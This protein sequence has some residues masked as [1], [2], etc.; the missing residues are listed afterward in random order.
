MKSIFK[1][2]L[3]LLKL[4]NTYHTK[5]SQKLSNYIIILRDIINYLDKL[6]SE[7]GYLRVRRLNVQ[8]FI[9][10]SKKENSDLLTLNLQIL[11]YT[12]PN[13]N[14]VK[15]LDLTFNS[16]LFW[17]CNSDS[18]KRLCQSKLN[19]LVKLSCAF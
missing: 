14:T 5:I 1:L 17:K 15:Y 2:V 11:K 16:T 6:A 7:N 12:S 18:L 3:L 13:S 8:V 19:L 10:F 9:H 4:Q